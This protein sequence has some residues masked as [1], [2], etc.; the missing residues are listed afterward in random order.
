MKWGIIKHSSLFKQ[1][2]FVR[3]LLRIYALNLN[4]NNIYI[5]MDIPLIAKLS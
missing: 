4:I 3:C 5:F 2:K 1:K